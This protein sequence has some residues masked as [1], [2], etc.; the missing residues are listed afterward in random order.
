MFVIGA[1]SSIKSVTKG[2]LFEVLEGLHKFYWLHSFLTGDERRTV[3][4]NPG[5]HGA[6]MQHNLVRFLGGKLKM[7]YL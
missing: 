2:C 3:F 5:E 7:F 6:K 1:T 4:Q